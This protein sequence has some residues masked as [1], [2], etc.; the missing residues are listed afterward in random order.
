MSY[1]FWKIQKNF[2]AFL[3]AILQGFSM[4]YHLFSYFQQFLV[5]KGV[6]VWPKQALCTFLSGT[7]TLYIQLAMFLFMAQPKTNCNLRIFRVEIWFRAQ[8]QNFLLEKV[9]LRKWCPF[10]DFVY[11]SGCH[12]TQPGFTEKDIVQNFFFDSLHFCLTFL[13]HISKIQRCVLHFVYFDIWSVCTPFF[14]L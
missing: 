8:E 10:F 11:F 14:P 1:K 4:V 13:H 12:F 6:C 5:Y 7:V 9:S 2:F 3:V